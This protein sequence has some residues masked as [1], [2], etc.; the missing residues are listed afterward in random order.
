MSGHGYLDHC[1]M[2]IIS[3]KCCGRLI[4]VNFVTIVFGVLGGVFWHQFFGGHTF[5]AETVR[6]YFYYIS[7][8]LTT[9][10]TIQKRMSCCHLPVTPASH[11]NPGQEF[12]CLSGCCALKDMKRI[13]SSGTLLP[14][15]VC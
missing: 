15:P 12:F 6:P 4:H 13:Q 11:Q 1:S 8:F 3:M 10:G 14:D 7:K 5:I 9:Y 2:K